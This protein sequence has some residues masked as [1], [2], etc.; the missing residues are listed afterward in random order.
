MRK[1]YSTLLTLGIGV[2][3]TAQTF[4]GVTG[5]TNQGGIGVLPNTGGVN[6]I[7]TLTQDNNH[8]GQAKGI[9]ADAGQ[10]LSQPFSVCVKL[11]FGVFNDVN[12]DPMTDKVNLNIPFKQK[13]RTGADGIAFRT[14]HAVRCGM[15]GGDEQAC[16]DGAHC[17]SR[18]RSRAEAHRLCCDLAL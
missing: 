7:F 9:W 11:N 4:T 8:F 10:N 12:L 1:F 17:G 5:P 13:D 2:A 15:A 6:T 16:V 3:A 14:V 18:K